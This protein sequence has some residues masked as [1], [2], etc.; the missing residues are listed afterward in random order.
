MLNIV[1]ALLIEHSYTYLQQVK[2]Q[3]SDVL[4]LKIKETTREV[5]K[6]SC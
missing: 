6:K 5:I 4:N 3:R 2:I 1:T